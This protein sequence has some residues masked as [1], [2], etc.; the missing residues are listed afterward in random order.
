MHLKDMCPT[1]RNGNRMAPVGYGNMDF[2]RII[3]SAEQAG[4]QYLLVEQ[5]DCYGEDPFACLN[6]SFGYL[7]SLGL[8]F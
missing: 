7:K 5:D 6:K 4:A 8:H 2:E 1:D 3:A